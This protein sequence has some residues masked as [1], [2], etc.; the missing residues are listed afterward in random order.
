MPLWREG[1][2]EGEGC[3]HAS[4]DEAGVGARAPARPAGC[5][6]PSDSC[7]SRTMKHIAP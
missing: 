4:A 2:A 5:R 1:R 3:P 6:I 7:R